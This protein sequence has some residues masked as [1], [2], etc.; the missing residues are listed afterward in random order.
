MCRADGPATPLEFSKRPAHHSSVLWDHD[1]HEIHET[2]SSAESEAE[3]CGDKFDFVCFL[4]SLLE[5]FLSLHS[6]S[7][8]LPGLSLN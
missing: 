7:K 1:L 3:L 5:R 4:E 6:I 2:S 8:A